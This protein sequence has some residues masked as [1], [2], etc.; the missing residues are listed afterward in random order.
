MQ[1]ESLEKQKRRAVIIKLSKVARCQAF[2]K[3]SLIT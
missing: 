3:V 1:N 2:C